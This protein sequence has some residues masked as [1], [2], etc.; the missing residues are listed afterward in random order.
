MALLC[1]NAFLLSFIEITYQIF[2]YNFPTLGTAIDILAVT[3]CINCN[4]QY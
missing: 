4:Q 1:F 2:S 3:L